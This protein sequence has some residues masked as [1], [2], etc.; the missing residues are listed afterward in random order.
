MVDVVEGRI[1]LD[2]DRQADAPGV[3]KVGPAVREGISLKLRGNI[4]REALA[5]TCLAI[6]R[7]TFRLVP[8]SFPD[9]EFA[10]MCAGLVAA[11]DERRLGLS[12]APQRCDGP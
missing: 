11:R 12:D 10:H 7:L 9:G 6:P 8:G 2:E 4:H 1:V 5:L 3:D